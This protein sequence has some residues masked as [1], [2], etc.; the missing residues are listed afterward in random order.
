MINVSISLIKYSCSI[1]K[2]I[3]SY[4]NGNGNIE[5][6]EALIMY[7]HESGAQA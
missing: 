4:Y 5:E 2:Y 6:I 1:K 7:P 3:F